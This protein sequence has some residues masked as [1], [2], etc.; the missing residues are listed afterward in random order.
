MFQPAYRMPLW[1]GL[2][3]RRV[4]SGAIVVCRS[5]VAAEAA[6]TETR[7]GNSA[8]RQAVTCVHARCAMMRAR[9]IRACRRCRLPVPCC[10]C[11]CAVASSPTRQHARCTAACAT[12]RSA[13]RPRRNRVRAAPPGNWT[14]RRS[15]RPICGATSACSAAPCTS[16]SRT[17]NWSTPR[18]TCR[19][20]ARTC[21]LPRSRRRERWRI[22]DWASSGRR[23]CRRM[24]NSSAPR[25]APPGSTSRGCARSRMPRAA[26]TPPRSRPRA[27]RG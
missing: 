26:S 25:R 3:S 17:G 11:C 18:A 15:P 9:P 24:P 10:A 13:W 14:M 4:E 21:A 22:P 16:A 27:R 20:R 5:L 6:P 23:N 7:V 8:E 19:A 1:Q 12:A 2:Q